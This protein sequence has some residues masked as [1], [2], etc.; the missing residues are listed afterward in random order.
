MIKIAH[1]ADIHIR[2]IERHEEYQIIFKKIYDE[3]NNIKP[4]RIVIVGDLFESFIEISNEAKI[5]AGELL[6]NLAKIAKV[7]ITRGNHD[8]RKKNT[9]RVDSVETIIK[10]INNPNIEYYNKTDFY[11]DNNIT[12]VV[13]EHT[14]KNNDPWL[15]K[16]KDVN[17]I[18]IGLF[19]DPIQ[20]S[21][22][23]VGKIFNDPKLYKDINY[24]K[25]NDFLLLGDIHKRQ[26][27]RKN[28]SAA[29]P[30][31]T[32]QQDFGEKV[33]NHG[34]LIW[35]IE[36]STNFKVDEYNIENEHSFV[37]LYVN[38][39]TDY[40]NLS[41]S[42]KNYA[43]DVEIKVHWKDYSSNINTINEKKIRDYI[44]NKF[45]TTKVKFD[46]T[47][48]YNDVV[49]SK[50]LSESLDLTDTQVQTSIFK[51]YLEEQKYK[52]DDIDEI[53][54]ID[55]IINKRL[56]LTNNKTNIEWSIDKFWFS[57]F[58]SYG[59]DN[60]INWKDVD[61]IYQIHGINKEGKTTILDAITYILYGKTTTTL[62]PEK[63][64]DSR[65][66]NNKR[67]L[68]YC[69]GGAVID[70]NGE[71][72]VIQRKTERVWNKNKTTLTSCPTTLDFYKDEIISEDNKLT[73]E[74]KRKTQES[75]DL[76]LGELKDFIRL[77]F[78]NADNLNDS[79]SE[80]RSVF[81][82]NIIR[83][84]G[85]DIF[86]TKLDEFKEYKKELSEEKL[87]VDVQQSEADVI[88]LKEN[89]KELNEEINLNKSK[90][91]EFEIELK[92]NNSDR[93]EFNKKLNNIDST[94]ISFD[95]NINLNSI[96]NYNSKI[97]ESNIQIVILDREIKSLPLQ[98]DNTK[99]N[100][101]K[102]KLKETN[103][104]ISERKDEISNIRGIIT[105]SENKKDKV[106]SKI[107]ELKESEIKK[108]LL[109]I[110]DN[111]LK[112]QI[113]KNEK[114]SIINKEINLITSNLQSIELEKNE[115][116]NKMKLFQKDGLNLKNLNDN[117]DKEIQELKNSSKCSACGRAF[118]KNDPDYT[119][120][121]AHL[122]EKVN[123][124]LIKKQDNESKIQ[125]LL[126]EY[127]KLK[128][129]L[130]DLE[131]KESDLKEKRE[132]LKQG[133]F[134]DEIKEKLRQIGSAKLLKEENL[135]IKNIIDEIKNNNFDN[136]TVLK[137]NISKG[138]Q[139]LKNI[140]KSKEENLLVI[141]NIE[142]ELR[143][144]NI[145]GIE[146]DINI[147]EKLKENYELRNK[148]IS[149]KDNLLLSMENFN[150]KIKELKSEIEKYQEYKLKI[151][152]NKTIQFSIDRID[153]KIL[154]IKENIKELTQENIEIEKD[155]LIKE[156][157]IDLI[158]TKIRKYLKQKKRDELLKEYQKC[159]SRD[160]LP[161]FLLKKSIH[162]INKELN[163]LLS[164]VDFTL[165][166]DENLILRMS[167]DDRLD[168]SQNA[169]ESSGMERTF[170]SLALKIALRQINVK[171]KPTFICLDEIMGKLIDSSVQQFVDFLEQLKTK[172]KKII[173]I[174]HVHPIDYQC[175]INVK[176]DNKLVSSLDIQY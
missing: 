61:G 102:I 147:E 122:E 41:L 34:F 72:F 171:S 131:L 99:L 107:K 149:Q 125:K 174:E 175:L 6:N 172:V 130:P 5:I 52:K 150:L 8:I 96:D 82:D 1:F 11:K 49:S 76:I 139:L 10:L 156:N 27:F 164:N 155:I 25:K 115:I 141:K 39:M 43:S 85:Y 104:K 51:E 154:I 30:G 111:D 105:E 160:G 73:G 26:F 4:D 165:F 70:V 123:Q 81:M 14:D 35:N 136:V 19:H 68:D 170:C 128:N 7:I 9:N 103:E 92:N 127:K 67:N 23:D 63:F 129:L 144:F 42:A 124:L 78:T 167:A 101:L 106:L 98:F 64:G 152:E 15:N 89:I 100:N 93:D 119:E 32:I 28:K 145:E 97:N 55:D 143:N 44:K 163:D 110:S 168:V 45:N 138:N 126:N 116:S 88:N 50:M 153:E 38:E 71:K 16:V 59:D 132:N 86:E 87:I 112:I 60:E 137:E 142:S 48:I 17:Q 13:Y 148:K 146:Q 69:L 33:E 120:H 157:E 151:E 109:K 77:S 95:E 176:K 31:S 135:K 58:K 53:L 83:D 40:D 118:D 57:N 3:L 79:L 117:L 37:N 80:T 75:L 12:W 161:T 173:I 169:I 121:L 24:F 162:L 18:Y 113:V 66:I 159:I 90:I 94:M 74:V 65:Y 47:Y 36:T 29:Y 166:F 140:E 108:L 20:D 158:S 91:E 46:K 56:H 2:N 84:A 62:S 22:T 114:E 21:S 134:S 133:I 54:K